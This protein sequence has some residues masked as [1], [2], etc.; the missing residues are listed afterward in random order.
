MAFGE[1]PAA[2]MIFVTVPREK[3]KKNVIS[4][5]SFGLQLNALGMLVA[6]QLVRLWAWATGLV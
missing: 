6:N 3:I 1:M 4:T 5:S 2:N